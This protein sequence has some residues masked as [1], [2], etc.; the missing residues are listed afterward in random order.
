MS[1]V[2]IEI[3]VGLRVPKAAELVVASLG[4]QNDLYS[5]SSAGILGCHHIRIQN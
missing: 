3:E 1:Y 5:Y 4:L 2:E